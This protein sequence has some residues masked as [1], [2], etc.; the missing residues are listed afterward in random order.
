MSGFDPVALAGRI[1]DDLAALSTPQRAA[2]EQAYLKSELEHF[3]TAVPDIR[4]VAKRCLRD[5]PDLTH[6]EL[7]ALVDELWSAPVHE[8]RMASVELLVERPKLLDQ[9]DLDWLES[10]LRN[11]FTWALVDSLAGIVVARIVD[12]Q[13]SGLAVLDRWLVDDD[14]W[15]RRSAVLGLRVAVRDGREIDRFLRYADVLLPEREFFIR[16]VLGW[17]AREIGQR[18]PA[19]ISA[20]LRA[21]M[22][23][24]NH[25]TL[26]EAVKYLPDGDQIVQL[27]QQRRPRPDRAQ[28]TRRNSV[29]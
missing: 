22:D 8:R 16:K 7:V 28:P 1:T 2:S 3:G 19:P 11:S 24:M 13:P 18:H 17:V 29:G 6:D 4:S 23:R 20:W 12:S 27:W 26:R 9:N 21:D 14:M 5:L 25:V 10:L 15:I